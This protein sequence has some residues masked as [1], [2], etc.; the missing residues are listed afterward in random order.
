MMASR[1]LRETEMLARL[2]KLEVRSGTGG[3]SAAATAATRYFRIRK[4]ACEE[5]ELGMFE[6]VR[7]SRLPASKCNATMAETNAST[8]NSSGTATVVLYLL[9][10]NTGTDLSTF[11]SYIKTLPDEGRG[12][13]IDSARGPFQG[14]MTRLTYAQA[15]E[16]SRQPFVNYIGPVKGLDDRGF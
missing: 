11:Q 8:S 16:V 14:H 15:K 7:H 9:V 10:T 6:Q 1:L 4:R 13:Q 3:V 12:Q 5:S 2:R